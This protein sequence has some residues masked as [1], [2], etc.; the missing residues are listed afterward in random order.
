MVWKWIDNYYMIRSLKSNRFGHFSVIS[1]YL[2]KI[3]AIDV[4]FYFSLN[5]LFWIFE[6]L[7]ED[8][9][10]CFAFI[11]IRKREERKEKFVMWLCCHFE[12]SSNIFFFHSD[13]KVEKKSNSS[14]FFCIRHTPH[15]SSLV[16]QHRVGRPQSSARSREFC[17]DFLC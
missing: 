5:L 12:S 10:F 14:A 16:P 4:D 11:Q 8:C 15:P 7:I 17:I 6:V 13:W 9:L 1:K 2:G 3:L